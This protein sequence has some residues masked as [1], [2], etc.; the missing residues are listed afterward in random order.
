MGRLLKVLKNLAD[1]KS[2]GG[3]ALRVRTQAMPRGASAVD[4][5]AI[6]AVRQPQDASAFGVDKSSCFACRLNL[7]RVASALP[8]R[9]PRTSALGG[10]IPRHGAGPTLPAN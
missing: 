5:A 4:T 2:A 7:T 9:T 10:A 8:I 1:I 6:G 3:V